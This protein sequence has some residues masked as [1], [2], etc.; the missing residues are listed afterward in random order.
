MNGRVI[1]TI[2]NN[3]LLSSRQINVENYASGI[4]FIRIETAT[5]STV[6]RIIKK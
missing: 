3:N 4:Y 1:Q 6:K 2:S 5:A